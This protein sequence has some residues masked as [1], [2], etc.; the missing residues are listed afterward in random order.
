[1]N[2]TVKLFGN[3]RRHLPPGQEAIAL[4]LA[5]GTSLEAAMQQLGVPDGEV[6]LAAVNGEAVPETSVL[7]DGDRLELFAPMGGGAEGDCEFAISDC[8]I[9]V[10]EV[11]HAQRLHRQDSAR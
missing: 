11:R 8:E 4:S 3:L 10:G 6:G 2:V 5:P 9:R 7:R 1:M